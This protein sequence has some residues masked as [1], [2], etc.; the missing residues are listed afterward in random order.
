M[1]KQYVD[2]VAILMKVKMEPY[3][4]LLIQMDV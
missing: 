2:C 1:M 4:N 3:T